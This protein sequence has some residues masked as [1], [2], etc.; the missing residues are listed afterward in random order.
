MTSF[1]ERPSFLEDVKLLAGRGLTENQI[2]DYYEVSM[3]QW[4]D[5]KSKYPKIGLTFARGRALAIS[6]VAGKLLD[7]AKG[8]DL[9]A[10]M[11]YLKTVG[12]FEDLQTA[13]EKLKN[14]I[15]NGITVNFND[16]NDPN[17]ASRL[18]Q[19]IMQGELFDVDGFGK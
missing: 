8:G 2:A 14:K 13:D 3:Q 17:E 9:K 15:Y 4:E 18:Y 10:I 6:E 11:Y 12:K 19:K 5:V 7:R 16:L 1:F